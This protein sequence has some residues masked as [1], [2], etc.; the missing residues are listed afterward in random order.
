MFF[1]DLNVNGKPKHF[2]G[3]EHWNIEFFRYYLGEKKPK[4]KKRIVRKGSEYDVHQ[5]KKTKWLEITASGTGFS[6]SNRRE[7]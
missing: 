4:L 1:A 7:W 6:V 3:L 2:S 5:I